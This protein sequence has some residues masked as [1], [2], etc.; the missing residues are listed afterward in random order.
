LIAIEHI[1]VAA[2]GLLL[3]S[4]LGSKASGRVGVPALLL[5][6]LIGMLA[7]SDGPGGVEFDDP[8][9]A[10]LLGV[11]ALAFILFAGGLDTKWGDV[12][13]VLW[14]A[15]GLSTLGVFIT[16]VSV[17]WFATVILGFSLLEGLLL[18]AIVSSTDAAAVFAVLRAKNA[19]LRGQLKPLLELE[20]GSNDPMAIFLTMGFT[21]L[22]L[23][24]QDQVVD[25]VPMFF[26][27]MV[28]GA[29]IGYGMG[30]GITALVNVLRLE[31]EGLYPVLT[32]ALVL[33]TYG[34]SASLGG[35][36]FLA[37]YL[38]GIVLGNSNF[39]H[40]KSLMQFHDGLAWLM[41]IAMFLTLGLLVFPSRLV[42][43][44]GV[45]LLMSIFLMLVAR[46][47]GVFVTLLVS[48][49]SF[50]EQAFVS[51]VGLRGAVPIILATFPLLAGVPQAEIMFDA[52]FF[53][54][55]TSVL[56]QGTT[57]SLV[58]RWLGV[59]AP[60]PVKAQYPLEFVPTGKMETESEEISIPPQAAAIGNQIV[61]L[62]LPNGALIVLLSRN[63][64][65][66][67]PNGG[68]VLEMGDSLLVLADKSTLP[69]V[70]S[71]LQSSPPVSDEGG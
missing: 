13:P 8:W 48:K 33:L 55:L 39:I 9:L 53:I 7:G 37:V 12:R 29:A 4:V 41:Q 32:M 58:A 66:M 19:S 43:V 17:G 61:D 28:V 24:P 14:S 70:R 15:T 30:R 51:W 65:F 47:V 54:V 60:A 31:Y 2:S 21:R 5:F 11:V 20:S 64:E 27:Q 26:L 71:A 1:L 67:V 68:T 22:L 52:V 42:Q 46:P 69:A 36:G 62:G 45:G 56:L 6:L 57:L 44:V 18:G 38:A 34:A 50:R 25:L 35:N 16:A 10:Q 3:L 63:G 49:V 59:D 23:N 40:K